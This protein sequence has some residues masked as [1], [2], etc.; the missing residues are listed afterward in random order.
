[1]L[2]VAPVKV[3]IAP[4]SMIDGGQEVRRVATE[5]QMSLVLSVPVRQGSW[6]EAYWGDTRAPAVNQSQAPAH[7]HPP[8]YQPPLAGSCVCN[9]SGHIEVVVGSSR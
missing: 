6:R 3:R 5:S 7:R 1:M 8:A 4:G 9:A 2:I